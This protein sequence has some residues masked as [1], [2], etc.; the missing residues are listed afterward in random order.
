MGRLETLMIAAIDLARNDLGIVAHNTAAT[1]VGR[2]RHA[3]VYR[4]PGL[5]ADALC[6]G[7][8]SGLSGIGYQLLRLA[9]PARVPSVLLWQ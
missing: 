4:L 8:F 2:A 7:L 3:G 5:A 1:V 6:P 9:H